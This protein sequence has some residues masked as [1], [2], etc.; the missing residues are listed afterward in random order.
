[1]TQSIAELV[2]ELRVAIYHDDA[3]HIEDLRQ[4]L[5]ATTFRATSETVRDMKRRGWACACE[6]CHVPATAAELCHA[7]RMA[8]QQ[9]RNENADARARSSISREEHQRLCFEEIRPM[10]FD[11]EP[12]DEAWEIDAILY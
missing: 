12:I 1:M 10:E 3:A 5:P 6:R 2:G 4:L 9:R 7:E 8:A 11:S